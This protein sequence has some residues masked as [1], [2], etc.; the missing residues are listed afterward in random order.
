M[1]TSPARGLGEAVDGE[2]SFQV[3]PIVRA[4]RI[5]WSRL[6]R[7]EFTQLAIVY[8]QLL[9]KCHAKPDEPAGK[10]GAVSQAIAA[11]LADRGEPFVKRMTAFA[12]AYSELVDDDHR[13]FAVELPAIEQEFGL[14]AP[15]A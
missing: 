9:A 10:P 13:Q 7:A 11:A 12:L 6:D 4:T 15:A 8:G 2:Q 3:K 14:V 5:E 1:Q